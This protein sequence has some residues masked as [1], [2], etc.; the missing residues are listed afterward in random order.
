MT[1]I[2]ILL[3]VLGGGVTVMV[4]AGMVLLT[5]HGVEAHLETPLEPTVPVEGPGVDSDPGVISPV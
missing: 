1:A 2:N 4:A 5:P 3:A